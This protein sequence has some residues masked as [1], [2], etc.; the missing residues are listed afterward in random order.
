[1]L[2]ALV[3]IPLKQF[4]ELYLEL[5]YY[6]YQQCTM[7]LNVIE[8]HHHAALRQMTT[9]NISLNNVMVAAVPAL[10]YCLNTFAS[11][12]GYAK[13]IKNDFIV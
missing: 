12:S 4:I 5:Q 10:T 7:Q 6:I 9:N 3:Q 11:T 8:V 1:M 13:K 2:D